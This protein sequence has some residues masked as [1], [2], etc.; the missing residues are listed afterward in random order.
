VLLADEP[1]G[2]QDADWAAELFQAF[3]WVAGKGTSCLV[4]THSQEFL[5]LVDRVATMRDGMLTAVA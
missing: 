2:H 3:R 1:T 5:K 4:A